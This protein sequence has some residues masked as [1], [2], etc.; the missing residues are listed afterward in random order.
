MKIYHRKRTNSSD[1]ND[2]DI[3]TN[4]YQNQNKVFYFKYL[5]QL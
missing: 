3:L 5:I 2:I 4:S 1:S